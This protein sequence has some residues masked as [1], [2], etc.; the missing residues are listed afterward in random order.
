M[1]FLLFV[2]GLFGVCKRE[3]GR[4]RKNRNH[5]YIFNVG[6]KVV[7]RIRLSVK[8]A[9]WSFISGIISIWSIL[10]MYLTHTVHPPGGATTLIGVFWGTQGRNLS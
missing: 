3:V 5:I 10:A 7:I 1:V 2:T 9:I 8:F 4:I 6:F